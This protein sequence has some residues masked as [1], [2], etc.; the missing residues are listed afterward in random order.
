MYLPPPFSVAK[1]NCAMYEDAHNPNLQ[2]GRMFGTEGRMI[3]SLDGQ[4]SFLFELDTSDV[5]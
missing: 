4:M 5:Q 1:N 3:T 2:N